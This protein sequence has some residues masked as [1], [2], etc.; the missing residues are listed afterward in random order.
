MN[1]LKSWLHRTVADAFS[2]AF[3]F[4]DGNTSLL[5]ISLAE[6]IPSEQHL[7]S[8]YRYRGSLTTPGCTQSVIWTVFE[9]PI[10]L[11]FDQVIISIRGNKRQA[12]LNPY[13]LYIFILPIQTSADSNLSLNQQ[14]Y[15]FYLNVCINVWNFWKYCYG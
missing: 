1:V 10:P 12:H 5:A 13:F 8:Y 9:N 15:S 7:T 2:V 3:L 14:K 4:S 11:N 6:L